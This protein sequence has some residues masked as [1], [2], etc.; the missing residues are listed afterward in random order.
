MPASSWQDSSTVVCQL[1][2]DQLVTQTL[3][4]RMAAEQARRA[5]VAAQK[6][7]EAIERILRSRERSLNV[8]LL[9]LRRRPA[10]IVE[11]T[12]VQRGKSHCSTASPDPAVDTL[13][14]EEGHVWECGLWP[15][16]SSQ[17]GLY[18]VVQT[19]RLVDGYDLFWF[20][21]R[22]ALG[23]QLGEQATAAAETS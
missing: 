3:Q 2:D 14:D 20:S 18:V 10:R 22:A 16:H 1:D 17:K 6:E 4:S 9:Q 21:W 5:V 11:A 19:D 13:N 15:P 7:S 12:P 8:R 23:L